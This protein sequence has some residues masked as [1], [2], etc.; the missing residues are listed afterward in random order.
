MVDAMEVVTVAV[1]VGEW[2]DTTVALQADERE[3]FWAVGKVQ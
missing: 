3:F 1:L 2:V